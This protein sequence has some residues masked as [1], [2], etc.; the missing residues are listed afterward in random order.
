[1]AARYSRSASAS[2]PVRKYALPRARDRPGGSCGRLLAVL[3]AASPARDSTCQSDAA[4]CPPLR[5]RAPDLP[6]AATRSWPGGRPRLAGATRANSAA[7][8]WNASRAASKRRSRRGTPSAPC[9]R[10][11]GRSA[12]SS[13]GD[14]AR[15]PRWKARGRVLVLLPAI[16]R[17]PSLQSSSGLRRRWGLRDLRSAGPCGQGSAAISAR[18]ARAIY[19]DVT[20]GDGGFDVGLEAARAA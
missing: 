1:M 7:R 5:R 3:A 20:L 4:R 11:R 2:R 18:T 13:A 10:C 14:R 16:N 19:L 12:P 6:T 8:F 17:C 15:S 9:A